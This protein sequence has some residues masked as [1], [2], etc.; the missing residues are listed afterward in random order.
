MT[1]LLLTFCEAAKELGI[2]RPSLYRMDAIV[3]LP[4]VRMA[5][6]GRRYVRADKLT[7]WLDRVTEA[8]GGKK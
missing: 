8:Q 2:S 5:E 7:E 1:T 4:C 6:G 3:P